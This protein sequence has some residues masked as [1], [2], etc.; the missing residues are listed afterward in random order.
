MI[1][2]GYVRA[3]PDEIT[4]LCRLR[5]SDVD[6]DRL[7]HVDE[8]LRGD[9]SRIDIIRRDRKQL[10]PNE[11]ERARE[12]KAELSS[13]EA[14]EATLRAERD[15]LWARLPNFLAPDT[16]PGESE[17]D[18]V[19]LTRWGEAPSP[20]NPKTH[21]SIGEELGILDL[22]RGARV[23]GAGY[24]YWKGDGAKLLWSLATLA[25]QF[26]L[27]RDFELLYTPVVT[28]K[29]TLFGTGYLPF[30]QDEL[31]KLEGEDLYLIGTSEQTLVGYHTDEILDEHAFPLRYAAFTPCFR[32]EA[33]AY[34]RKARGAFRVHQFHKL[35][36]IVFCKEQDS[37]DWHQRCQQNA[38]EFMQLLAVPYRVVRVC[39]GDLGAPGYK[40]YD[41]E[42]WFA[43][44]GE[45]RETHSNT[46]LLDYQTRRLKTRYRSDRE[47]R[48]PHTIS[49]TMV[50]DRVAL[51]ILENNQQEDGSV[52]VPKALQPFMG[53]EQIKAR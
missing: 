16:P 21:E 2:L 12:L 44:F 11:R 3:H 49:A 4:A 20:P 40:K 50:T 36:Q 42:G 18:N 43:G 30:A 51:A 48:L 37:E 10:A 1:D 34:G 32:T 25:T 24:Y 41:I 6:V 15:E 26:L 47:T 5:G 14:E 17:R 13:L 27:D 45:Y 8:A 53:M 38:E 39:V 46:N 31:Y 29:H 7:L 52:L 22:R 19:E 28:R 35:E 33:G 23:T 9:L